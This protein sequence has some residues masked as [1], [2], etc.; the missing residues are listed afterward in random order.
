MITPPPLKPGS[1]VGLVTPA[2][3]IA[4]STIENAVHTIRQLGYR[5]KLGKHLLA[6]EN[7]LAGND[8][9]RAADFQRQLDDPEI[10]MILCSRGGYGS[11]RIIDRL[12]FSAF[13]KKPKWIAGYSDITVFHAHLFNLGFE[14]LHCTMPLDFP[15]NGMASKPVKQLFEAATGIPLE[16]RFEKSNHN[17]MGNA[18]GLLAG[19]NLSVFSGLPGSVSDIDTTEKILFLEDVGEDLYRIDRMMVSLKRAG[20]LN[21]LNGLLL[22]GFTGLNPGSPRFDFTVEEIIMD[23]VSQFDYPVAFG[24]PA[25][26]FAENYPLVMGR[27]MRMVVG[28]NVVLRDE[29]LAQ[30]V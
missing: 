25:G 15:E 28:E 20:K 6:G 24:F 4:R 21:H 26:H 22:G 14:S 17:I 9:Q 27:K 8:A 1:T 29:S 11:A 16:Y 23:A 7:Y 18:E 13:K 2:K 12:D 19:G 30:S 5:V 3:K 10:A